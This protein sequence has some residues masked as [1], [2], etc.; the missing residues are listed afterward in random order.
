MD[1]YTVVAPAP[2]EADRGGGD[3]AAMMARHVAAA[4]ELGC[5]GLVVNLIDPEG[6]G[7]RE[8]QP[9]PDEEAVILG[10]SEIWMPEGTTVDAAGFGGDWV[11]PVD[12]HRQKSRARAWRPGTPSPGVKTIFGV[13]RKAPQADEFRT[14]W[15]DGHVPLALRHHVGMCAYETDVI[16]EVPA[17]ALALDGFSQLHFP[18]ERDFSERFYDDDEGRAEIEADVAGFVAS[19]VAW[20]VTEYVIVDPPAAP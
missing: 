2:V 5:S 4:L 8:E 15:L 13:V 11:Y 9:T 14:A 12:G 3:G 7:P 18:S 16:R 6:R 10:A 1:K 20:E 19:A 17:D